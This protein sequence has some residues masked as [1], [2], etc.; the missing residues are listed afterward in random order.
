MFLAEDKTDQ[1]HWQ[2]ILLQENTYYRVAFITDQSIPDFLCI[3]LP[4]APR[5]DAGE[6]RY[7]RKDECK[8]ILSPCGKP[9]GCST[10]SEESFLSKKQ[11]LP[12]IREWR[13]RPNSMLKN[14][15]S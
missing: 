2:A 9:S 3:F 7:V 5:I 12:V 4:D 8:I 10:G 15:I 1:G 14:A 6:V 13:Q 11:S